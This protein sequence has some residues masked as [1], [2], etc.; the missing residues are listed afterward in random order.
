MCQRG[1]TSSE[2]AGRGGWQE[3]HEQARVKVLHLEQGAAK[4]T[5]QDLCAWGAPCCRAP[6]GP[7]RR[8]A[9]HESAESHW[10][11]KGKSAPG[12]HLQGHH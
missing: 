10:S 9:E 7:G 6:G 4:S 2:A 3:L 5:V 8:Q 11:T 12:F 1:V